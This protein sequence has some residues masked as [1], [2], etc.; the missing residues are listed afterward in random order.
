M[1]ER[2]ILFPVLL[3]IVRFALEHR[4][5]LRLR[6]DDLSVLELDTVFAQ[7]PFRESFERLVLEVIIDSR[8]RI[9]PNCLLTAA[10]SP[11]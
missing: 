2:D 1:T 5:E 4:N 6:A 7:K 10:R 11:R 9:P 8:N 3:V